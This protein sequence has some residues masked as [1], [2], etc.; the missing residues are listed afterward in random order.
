MAEDKHCA[1]KFSVNRRQNP[2]DTVQQEDSPAISTSSAN[3]NTVS[4]A[5]SDMS[6]SSNATGLVDS[7]D[8]DED[9]SP[10]ILRLLARGF[11]DSEREAIRRFQK[12][13]LHR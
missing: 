7:G 12:K 5:A 9:G 8:G 3:D 6:G 11:E 2:L 4:V 1:A 10:A 13:F